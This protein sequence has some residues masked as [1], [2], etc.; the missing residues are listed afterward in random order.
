M[1][2]LAS[3]AASSALL[4]QSFALKL[5]TTED[6]PADD[7]AIVDDAATAEEPAADDAGAADDALDAIDL[8]GDADVAADDEPVAE[9]TNAA[10][11]GED[12]AEA[13]PQPELDLEMILPAEDLEPLDE[14]MLLPTAEDR[15]GETEEVAEAEGE[16]ADAAAGEA[17]EVDVAPE[18]ES[19]IVVNSN[20]TFTVPVPDQDFAEW[21]APEIN[22]HHPLG[23]GM[24]SDDRLVLN[25]VS[26]FHPVD[27]ERELNFD[28]DHMDEPLQDGDGIRT[29]ADS[30]I[31]DERITGM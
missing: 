25:T 8:E 5:S 18:E 16:V 24:G 13:D 14:S 15:E 30:V 2:K 3:I 9:D 6:P 17:L 4:S 11:A 29:L 23:Q 1:F 27:K 21:K 31:P 10:G 12:E 19:T 7:L 20:G 22:D 28:Y 26:V